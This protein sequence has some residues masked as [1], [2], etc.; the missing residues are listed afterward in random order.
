M[1]K[2]RLYWVDSALPGI[3]SV[4]QNGTDLRVMLQED[5]TFRDVTVYQVNKRALMRD[6]R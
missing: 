6:Y 1:V 4:R 2:C 3:R 5:T